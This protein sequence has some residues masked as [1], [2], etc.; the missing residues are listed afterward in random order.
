MGCSGLGHPTWRWPRGSWDS[1]ERAQARSFEKAADAR[2]TSI[3]LLP[4]SQFRTLSASASAPGT[5][6]AQG[7]AARSLDTPGDSEDCGSLP[8]GRSATGTVRAPPARG[9][10]GACPSRETADCRDRM[11]CPARGRRPMEGACATTGVESSSNPEEP[12]FKTVPCQ[13]HRAPSR[14]ALE[15]V[16]APTVPRRSE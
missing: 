16:R 5:Q 7:R 4:I 8:S 2:R 12:L 6:P 14:C 3:E 10:R 13:R 11:Q 9:V 1:R 15:L